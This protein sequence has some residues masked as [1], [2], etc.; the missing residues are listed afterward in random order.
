MVA[1]LWQWKGNRL[2]FDRKTASQVAG[3]DSVGQDVT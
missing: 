2:K 3:S 1:A